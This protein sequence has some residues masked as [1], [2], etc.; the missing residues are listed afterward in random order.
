MS[1]KKVDAIKG[2][3]I[4]S[5]L[6]GMFWGGLA[7]ILLK[8]E[9]QCLVIPIAMSITIAVF[10]SLWAIYVGTSIDHGDENET[11]DKDVG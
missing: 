5:V 9:Y 6:I 3:T 7:A 4:T 1:N 11:L 2:F 10:A 8:H